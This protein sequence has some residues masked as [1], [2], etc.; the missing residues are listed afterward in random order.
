VE[1]AA[2]AQD[3]KGGLGSEM[4]LRHEGQSHSVRGFFQACLLFPSP[5]SSW[6]WPA[7]QQ[8][9]QWAHSRNPTALLPS[10]AC[11]VLPLQLEEI[12]EG[13]SREDWSHEGWSP[14]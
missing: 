10:T 13:W 11:L 3:L 5:A 7:S 4:N 2:S 14:G 12:P 8:R 9:R 6:H 1:L